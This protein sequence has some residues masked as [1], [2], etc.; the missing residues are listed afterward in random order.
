MLAIL[1]GTA[2]LGGL[3]YGK[4]PHARASCARAQPLWRL[5]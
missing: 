2:L 4:L 1:V 5:F 3:L